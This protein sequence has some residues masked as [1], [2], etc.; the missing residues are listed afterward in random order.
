MKSL[1]SI[2]TPMYNSEVFIS[3]TINSVLCQTYKNWELIL[4]D[5]CSNDKTLEVVENFI[6]KNPSIQLI[7]N[8]SNK[9][10]AFSRNKGIQTAKGDYIAFLDADDLWKPNKLEI[11]LAFMESE[12]CHVCFSSYDL[13]NEKSE[14]L[15]KQ[16]KALKEIDY[17]KLLKSNY[18][19]NL[20]G[21]YNAKIIG[22]IKTPNLRKRQ[23]WLLWLAAI[24]KYGKPAKGIQKSLACYRIRKDSMSS[25][26]LNLIKYNYQ[27]YKKGLGFS[28]LKSLYYM[29]IFLNEHFFVKSKQTVTTNEI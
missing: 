26:K 29:L 9:G 2:I 24:N 28:T 12:N 25:N 19:G 11:Q 22:K 6:V 5:D 10:A 23:D 17:S 20:T 8:S 13:I 27:V 21:I 4:I 18:I 14:S 15:N 16:V 3:E 7:K 1:V